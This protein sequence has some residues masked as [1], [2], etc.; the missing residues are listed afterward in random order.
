QDSQLFKVL[1]FLEPRIGQVE[2]SKLED[3]QVLERTDVPQSRVGDI[4]APAQIEQR[5][6]RHGAQFGQSGIGDI[7]EQKVQ[8]LELFEPEE[9]LESLVRNARS[10]QIDRSQVGEA[11]EMLEARVG[12]DRAIV[13]FEVHEIRQALDAGQRVVGDPAAPQDKTLQMREQ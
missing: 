8:L 5:D 6:L 10:P 2:V 9:R 1:E 13:E 7:G 12:D 4:A 11:L 3:P